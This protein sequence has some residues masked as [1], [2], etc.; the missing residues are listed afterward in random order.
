MNKILVS[1]LLLCALG[2]APLACGNGGTGG[3]GGSSSGSG[4]SGGAAS[5]SIPC[6]QPSDPNSGRVACPGGAPA[7]GTALPTLAAFRSI[8]DGTGKSVKWLGGVLGQQ[9]ARD[10]TPTGGTLSLWMAGFCLGGTGASDLG[11]GLNLSANATECQVGR[12]CQ[13][14]DCSQS[15]DY[16]FPVIDADAAITAAFPSDPAG[17]TYGLSYTA[18]VGDFWSVTSSATGTSVKI[19]AKTGAVIP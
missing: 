2:A 8:A 17:T 11:D 7:S 12:D 1:L 18:A 6:A 16:P 19:D 4:G 14:L 3:S 13:A 10:G 15:P 9:V 5:A